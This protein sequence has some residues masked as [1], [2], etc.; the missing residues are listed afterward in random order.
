MA[1]QPPGITPDCPR[2]V[3]EWRRY[4][5]AVPAGTGRRLARGGAGRE[6]VH[7]GNVVRDVRV[8]F[9]ANPLG[10]DLDEV[11]ECG[12]CGE[13]YISYIPQSTVMT[14][15][16]IR[17]RVTANVAGTG[18]ANAMHLA[19]DSD[20]GPVRWPTMTCDIAYYM[21]VDI[22]PDE[23]LDLDVRLAVAQRE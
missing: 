9:Y 6:T 18:E 4:W 8:R 21:T 20:Y 15:D 19:S 13:F 7:L 11:D 23:V 16:G 22:A 5:T 12:A 3:T 2:N 14:I 1:P 17:K 10:A